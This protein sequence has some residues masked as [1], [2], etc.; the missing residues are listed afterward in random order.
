MICGQYALVVCAIQGRGSCFIE[1]WSDVC[2]I[3][4]FAS[5]TRSEYQRSAPNYCPP[6]SILSHRGNTKD[7]SKARYCF[8]DSSLRIPSW[9]AEENLQSAWESNA[10]Y[11]CGENSLLAFGQRRRIPAIKHPKW[12][13]DQGKCHSQ[14]QA[15]QGR[16]ARRICTD[17]ALAIHILRPPINSSAD[18]YP[19]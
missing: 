5:L 17:G 2:A 1:G 6:P 7:S 13:G 9:K 3:K 11:C 4:K 12:Q 18:E 14:T 10:A 15:G 16:H 19:L 8:E